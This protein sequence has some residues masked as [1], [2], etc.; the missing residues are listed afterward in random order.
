[1]KRTCVQRCRDDGGMVVTVWALVTITVMTLLIGIAVDLTGQLAGLRQAS[2][3]AGQ[4]A[5]TA[6]QQVATDT[7][8]ADGRSVTVT[9]GRAKSA[10]LAYIRGSGMTGTAQIVDGNL[11]VEATSQY[12]TRFLSIIGIPTITVIGTTATVRIA[13]ALNGEERP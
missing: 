11:V 6:A 5:R 8:L 1:M 2:D 7:Y 9:A 3:V 4:A 10:A 13:R 12:R